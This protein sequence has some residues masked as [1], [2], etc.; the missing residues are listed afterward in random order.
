MGRFRSFTTESESVEVNLSY[1][2]ALLQLHPIQAS[3]WMRRYQ[4]HQVEAEQENMESMQC[5]GTQERYSDWSNGNHVTPKC[6]F[7]ILYEYGRIVVEIVV[8]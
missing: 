1:C 8:L 3:G 5:C 7:S 2:G 6:T 4:A